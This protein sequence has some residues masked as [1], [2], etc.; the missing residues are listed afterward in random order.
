MFESIKASSGWFSPV[1]R[2]ARYR[3]LEGKV[4]NQFQISRQKQR[5]LS[6]V[7]QLEGG[8]DLGVGE[9]VE[10]EVGVLC[11]RVRVVDAC[12]GMTRQK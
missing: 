1:T 6:P 3:A 8:G 5:L 12:A 9:A 2:R 11:D 4:T 7:K 10:G